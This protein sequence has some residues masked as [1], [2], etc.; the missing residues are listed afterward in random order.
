MTFAGALAFLGLAVLTMDV[1]GGVIATGILLRGGRFRHLLAFCAGYTAVIIPV[2][3][4]LHPLLTV[5][6]TW[7]RP[8]LH[9]NDAI[10]SVEVVAGLALAGFALHQWRAARR[11]PLPHGRLQR[12]SSPARLAMWPLLAAG[13]AFSATALADP[14]FTIA[15]GMAAQEESLP[16]RIALLVLW[17]LVYQAPLVALT[18]ISA[19]G[20]QDRL[21]RRI[22]DW[23]VERRRPLQ[24][25][26]AAVLAVIALLVLGDGTI[27]LIGEHV[28][29]LRQLLSLR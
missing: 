11:P 16:L 29:W 7:L 3:L 25:A 22:A 18:I 1:L 15:V 10:G 13:L 27:A 28:P 26:L 9:S 2:T 5:L 12:R 6:G 17:H 23:F 4:L 14:A 8:I 21:V 19:A 20:K 24:G